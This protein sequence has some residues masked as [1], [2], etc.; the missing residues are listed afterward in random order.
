MH[1]Q[2]YLSFNHWVKSIQESFKLEKQRSMGMISVHIFGD[3][4]IVLAL[5]HFI[6]YV[7]DNKS[8]TPQAKDQI[9]YFMTTIKSL[10][11]LFQSLNRVLFYWNG[12]FYTLAKRFFNIRYIYA[13]PWYHPKRPLHVFKILS[14]LTAVHLN[15]L[16]LMA[17]F[18]KRNVQNT[19]E[20]HT[21]KSIPSNSSKC[22]LCLDSRQH[23]SLTFCGHLFC[24]CC[25][26]EWLQTKNFCPICQK[27]L[28][29]RNIIALQ[30]FM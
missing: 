20:E 8:I 15:I 27:T 10:I 11:P 23:T 22:P 17:L 30:N 6:D 5:K 24:W 13:V 3:H 9:I 26:H 19:V 18:K 1:S 25:I 21:D 29:S 12:S 4:L 2:H 28:N 7:R 16:M 14:V